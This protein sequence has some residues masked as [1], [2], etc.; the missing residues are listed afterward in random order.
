MRFSLKF[1]ITTLCLLLS[2][3]FFCQPPPQFFN[4]G[5]LGNGPNTVGTGNICNWEVSRTLNGP[6][7]NAVQTDAVGTWFPNQAT[8]AWITWPNY[9]CPPPPPPAPQ[10]FI[11]ANHSCL[12][13]NPPPQFL[14]EDLY[15]RIDFNLVNTNFSINWN[16]FCDDVIE[17]VFVNNFGPAIWTPNSGN[18]NGNFLNFRNCNGWV[19]GNNF[20]IVHVRSNSGYIGLN[21]NSLGPP[22]I[23]GPTPVCQGSQAVY[24]IPN[25]PGATYSWVLPPGWSG[26]S[27]SNQ[28]NATVGASPGTIYVTS[29]LG[30]NCIGVS[31]LNV[32]ILPSP[33]VILN[34]TANQVCSGSP[35]TLSA[36]G[37]SS[38]VWNSNSGPISNQ[39]IVTVN[40]LIT[41]NYN[42]VGTNPNG[43]T[44]S[45]NITINTLPLPN[46]LINAA[47][48]VICAGIPN[49]LTASGAASYL[50][51][52]PVVFPNNTNPVITVNHTT[53]PVTYNV[54][55]TG[56]NGCINTAAITLTTG[57]SVL[58]IVANATL[59]TNASNCFLATATTAFNQGP[60]N[61]IWQQPNGPNLNGSSVNL[62]PNPQTT[63]F[64]NV[65]GTSPSGCSASTNMQL[66]I[67]TN[68]CSQPTTCLS[69]LPT[70]LNSNVTP[71]YYLIDND[72]TINSSLTFSGSEFQIMPGKKIIVPSGVTLTLDQSHLYACG[73]KMWQGIEVLDG[74][75]IVTPARKNSSLIEDA[76]IAIDLSNISVV[77]SSPNRPIQLHK[78]IFNK[79]HIGIKISNGASALTTLPLTISECVFTSRNIPFTTCPV[80]LAWPNSDVSVTGLRYATPAALAGLAPPYLQNYATANIK[81][82]KNTTSTWTWGFNTQPGQIGIQIENIGNTSGTVPGNG[83]EFGNSTAGSI[84]E[85]NLFD[86][87]GKGI[88]VTDAG[89]TTSNNV[90]Q[91]INNITILTN[92]PSSYGGNG[93]DHRINTSG[94]NMNAKLNLSPIV[95]SN[96]YGN[97][98]WNNTVPVF[99]SNVY[100]VSI[101]HG[102]FRS[103]RTTAAGN[104]AVAGLA[105]VLLLS[106]RFNYNVLYNEFNNLHYS[107]WIS[108]LNG[109]YDMGGS[110]SSSAGTY[111]NNMEINQNYFGPQVSSN[112]APGLNYSNKAI[113][114][115][116]SGANNWQM[117][118]ICH[119][120]GNKL[121]Q[122]YRGIKISNMDGYPI[123]I[124]GNDILLETDNIIAPIAPQHGIFAEN[125][126]DNLAI[127]ENIVNIPDTSNRRVSCFHLVNNQGS[128]SYPQV[129]CNIAEN[130]YYG[131]HFDGNNS[132]ATWTSNHM[133]GTRAGL[134]LENNALIGSQGMPGLGASNKWLKPAHWTG[135][136]NGPWTT[137]CNNSNGATSPL[138]VCDT[139]ASNPDHISYPPSVNWQYFGGIAY[140]TTNGLF[141]LSGPCNE[142]DCAYNTYPTPPALRPNSTSIEEDGADHSSEL[143]FYPNPSNG[144]IS[145]RG[146][147]GS[148]FNK[149]T[150]TDL[151]GKIIFE[152]IFNESIDEDLVT[153]EVAKG[154]YFIEILDKD[155]V[156]AREKLLIE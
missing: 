119:V 82:P 32:T 118:G 148:L 19:V 117:A 109:P 137:L 130:G 151:M 43:C 80:A 10:Q 46:V 69:L 65:I 15:F 3:K 153:L 128:P 52:A 120:Y 88:E 59:C 155:K 14:R 35:V 28:I 54:T 7:I 55:G 48:Q 113:T 144:K 143:V 133:T 5:I 149:I 154:I 104:S 61:F 103:T 17:D 45:K 85:F 125:S 156:I 20:I 40:P 23:T 139:W 2:F 9:N 107:L 29:T 77:N 90:F 93:I 147:S 58:P 60:V 64:Y 87:L 50:W 6:Y 27:T 105:G 75:R 102:I 136:P 116:N 47:P 73:I 98:F 12:P 126:M 129:M 114:I 122:V 16:I 152:K 132:N 146:R 150:L 53:G 76:H 25:I 56:A 42:V 21:I 141:P 135:G 138:W 140:S 66:D 68:C 18:F 38:Y 33:N 71:G 131:F 134:V 67:T 121:N 145:V 11:H 108:I 62:C 4:T 99:C 97:R 13:I 86:N 106:N 81:A 95:A 101:R 51:S 49:V 78:V 8:F 26:S 92:P 123:E 79:N 1:T 111:A 91:L 115:E 37:A 142:M 124:G 57:A 96:S 39:P 22:V 83:V 36:S 44:N 70:T 41:T 63:T 84:N 31:S 24:S 100:D 127:K 30:G 94:P 110:N 89:L 112:I 72:V 74:G 34:S